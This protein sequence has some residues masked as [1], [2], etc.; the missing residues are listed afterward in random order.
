M[1]LERLWDK[2]W[3]VDN[4]EDIGTYAVN[5]NMIQIMPFRIRGRTPHDVRTPRQGLQQMIQTNILQ[6]WPNDIELEHFNEFLINPNINIRYALA[7]SS[8]IN[9]H[10]HHL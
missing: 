6:Q 7:N 8:N 1:A 2:Q 5:E 4:V 9:H 10:L 3:T